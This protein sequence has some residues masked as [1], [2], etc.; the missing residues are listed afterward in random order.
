MMVIITI[1]AV[2]IVI[3]YFLLRRRYERAAHR[4]LLERSR[5]KIVLSKVEEHFIDNGMNSVDAFIRGREPQAASDYLVRFR[6]MFA[7]SL[8]NA[9]ETEV[10]LEDDLKQL[11]VFMGLQ[12]EQYTKGPLTYTIQ[13]DPTI[14]TAVAAVPPMIF[15][16]LVENAVKYAFV[17]AE[18]GHIEI[19]VRRLGNMMEGTVR[20]NGMGRSAARALREQHDAYYVKVR[21]SMGT[22]LAEEIVRLAG[23]RRHKTAFDIVDLFDEGGRPAGT[24]ARFTLP[25]KRLPNIFVDDQDNYS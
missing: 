11:Q 21:A 15:Q 16:V 2:A 25:Y 20:D 5:Q 23:D 1:F 6:H 22:A 4:T 10:S 24:L 3:G 17:K 19:T 18:G 13:M 8:K 12:Q 14:D 9:S 7:H